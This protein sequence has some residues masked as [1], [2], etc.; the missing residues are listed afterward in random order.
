MEVYVL[1]CIVYRY[2][3]MNIIN[4][5]ENFSIYGEKI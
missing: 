2:F 5:L 1:I 4:I 3:E